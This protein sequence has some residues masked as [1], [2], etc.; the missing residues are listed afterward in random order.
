MK[1]VDVVI[2][3]NYGDEGKGSSV[4]HL[5]KDS[6]IVVRFN[7]GAQAGHTV[8]HDNIRHVFHSFGSGTLKGCPTYFSSDFY[9][10]PMM[11]F[12]E[13]YSISQK[14]KLKFSIFA[15][16]ECNIV[17]PFDVLINQLL[18]KSRGGNRHGSCGM[19][20]GESVRR[21]N[22]GFA[23]K[24]KDIGK[25]D[26]LELIEYFNKRTDELE[27]K[28]T[29]NNDLIE[30]FRIDCL[31]FVKYVKLVDFDKIDD[32][33]D[34]IVFEG[35]QGLRLDQN[36]KDFPHVT[37]SN[38]GLDNVLKLLDKSRHKLNV[39]YITR[40]YLTRHGAGPLNNE[41]INPGIIDETNMPNDY[42]GSLRFSKMD[43]R[44]KIDIENDFYKS[45]G[46]L[47]DKKLMISCCDHVK[48]FDDDEFFLDK[49][50]DD[51]GIDDYYTCWGAGHSWNYFSRL[52][53]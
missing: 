31:D 10:D 42:Q 7:G 48:Y 25:V 47:S 38:T 23:L 12:K 15:D 44:T 19:G 24:L 20:F 22:C 52:C 1:E 32:M 49:L 34:N 14:K 6:T 18:E 46:F 11:F 21:S 17:T 26:V 43:G 2:G 53:K 27:I 33:F 13:A 9:V 29:I 5:C 45:N 41:I 30:Q 3:S 35:A 4:N 36:S 8:V 40:P 39:H 51:I 50:V 28:I 37:Y 16:P